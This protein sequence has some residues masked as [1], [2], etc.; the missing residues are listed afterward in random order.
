[1]IHPATELVAVD[2]DIGL[3]VRATAPIPRGTILWTL[4]R[5]DRTFSPEEAAA[6]SPLHRELLEHFGYRD[7][8]GRWILCWD[9]G[10]YVNHS[11]DPAMRGVGPDTMIAM[12]DLAEGEPVTCDYAECNLDAPLDCRCGAPGCRGRVDGDDLLRFADRWDPLVREAVRAAA[13]VDQ[14]LWPAVLDPAGLR[15]ILD[16]RAP[17]PSLRAVHPRG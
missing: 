7:H 3:G 13:A 6:L 17:V 15:A 4:D 2:P 14:P 16:G 11:C 5:F 10:R 9:A 1:M 12:R 8:T